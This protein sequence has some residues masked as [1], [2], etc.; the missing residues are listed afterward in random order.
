MSGVERTMWIC[1]AGMAGFLIYAAASRETDFDPPR[2]YI[3]GA[4]LVTDP[5]NGCQY[6]VDRGITPRLKPDGQQVCLG[7]QQ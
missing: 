6:L 3:G 5:A 7:R 1:V 4:K 2:Q